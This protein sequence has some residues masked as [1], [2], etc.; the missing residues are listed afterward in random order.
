MAG[1]PKGN[2]NAARGRTWRDAID[3]AMKRNRTALDKCADALLNAAM[4][5]DMTALKELGDRLDGK[6]QQAIEHSGSVGNYQAMPVP[7][8][9]REPIP[10]V[11]STAGT[12]ARS[13]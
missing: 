7:V 12:A 3:R 8:E 4:T 2:K 5:G 6:P 9:E 13:H 10:S 1:A 11:E